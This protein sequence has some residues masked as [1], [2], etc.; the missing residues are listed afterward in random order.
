MPEFIPWIAPPGPVVEPP[1]HPKTLVN[2]VFSDGSFDTDD[3]QAG[4]FNWSSVGDGPKIIAYAVV[5]EYVEPVKAREWWLF[6]SE[7]K[8]D[9]LCSTDKHFAQRAHGNRDVPIIPVRKVL[10][11]AT[12]KPAPR[13]V[14]AWAVVGIF[15]HPILLCSEGEA[16]DWQRRN[17]GTVRPLGYL[18]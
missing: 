13:E 6:W 5:Q 16:M 15:N 2:L 4:E 8:K 1:V 12:A 3:W 18:P 17:G 7:A 11:D 9:W 10:P 14:V